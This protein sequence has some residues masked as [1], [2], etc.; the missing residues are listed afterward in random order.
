MST[1]SDK[2][3]A[4]IRGILTATTWIV[5]TTGFGSVAAAQ[6]APGTAAQGLEEIIVTAQKREQSVQDVPITLSV[7]SSKMITDTGAQTLSDL[8][9]MIP[10]V[11]GWTI[12][13]QNSIWAIRG[14]S[15]TTTD[16]GGEPS[17]GVYWDES[18]AGYLDFAN[19]PLFDVSRVEVAKGPQGT[20]Y[21]K[22][23]TAGAISV[24]TNRPDTGGDSLDVT[25]AFGNVGQLRGALQGNLA[26][27]DT[28]AVRLS[29]MYDERGD[30]QKNMVAGGELGSYDRWGVRLGATWK[31]TTSAG[32]PAARAGVA[33][34]GTS[35]ATR[36]PRT[37]TPC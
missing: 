27:N 10:A 22:N 36:T 34:C 2:L 37:F 29:G 12:G 14:M 16:G 28:L 24:Y 9:P 6:S 18:Y 11:S 20:L 17:V 15:S 4:A 35:P 31:A 7:V 26:V 23:S 32:R 5:A 13:V 25:G 3:S 19:T 8:I 1:H 30:Y 21:G 33:M